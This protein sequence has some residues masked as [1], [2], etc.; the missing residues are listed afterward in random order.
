M[1]EKILEMLKMQEALD[2]SFLQYMGYD[3]LDIDK[4]RMALFDE[5]GE[6]NHEMKAEWCYWKKSQKPV[7][8]D[9]LKEELSDVWH[10]ALT[11]HRLE[12]GICFDGFNTEYETKEYIDYIKRKRNNWFECLNRAINEDDYVLFEV[13]DLTYALG[14]TFDDIYQAYIDKNKENYERMK[15]GY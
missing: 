9:K 12:Y 11:L 14:F 6:V 2:N 10:F 7:D 8:R 13:F 1:K 15:R 3:K 5:L 4:V